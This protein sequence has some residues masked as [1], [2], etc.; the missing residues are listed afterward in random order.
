M[1]P[2]QVETFEIRG[3][4]ADGNLVKKF[5][6]AA[7]EAFV[8]P[9][10]KVKAALDATFG[11]DGKLTAK[12]GAKQSAGSFKATVQGLSGTI[13]G[14]LVPAPPYTQDFEAFNITEDNTF[15]PGVK[16]AYPPLPWIGFRF[17]WEVRELDGNKVLAKTLD[18]NLFQRAIGFIGQPDMANYT[19]QADVMTAKHK[20]SMSVVG[21][22]NQR[23]IIS[24]DGNKQILEIVSNHD[25][26]KA[27]C[28]FEMKANTWYILR[29]RVD[30]SADGSGTIW[31][32]AWEKGSAEPAEW[33]FGAKHAKANTQGS[34]GLY[35]FALQNMARVYIDNVVVTPNGVAKKE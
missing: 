23:Y 22:I 7:W 25:L 1:R 24:L 5:E 15:E 27:S 31:A 13:R 29:T 32:K 34:P 16:F 18:N 14:R 19:L 8:P 3:L 12:E 10:A 26:F 33:T 35:G 21:V 9:T 20:R 17:K 11:S 6:Q 2:G 4:N 30:L 28:P